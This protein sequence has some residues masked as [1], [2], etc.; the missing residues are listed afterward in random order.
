MIINLQRS[1]KMKKIFM[2]FLVFFNLT[3]S[4]LAQTNQSFD[5]LVNKVLNGK[6]ETDTIIFSAIISSI[7]KNP[8]QDLVKRLRKGSMIHGNYNTSVS[9]TPVG[10]SENFYLPYNDSE[11][12]ILNK[13][14]E[15]NVKRNQISI[16]MRGVFYKG[17]HHID[18]KLFFLIDKIWFL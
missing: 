3:F 2:F 8:Q 9:F 14:R 6:K 10:T 16:K 12:L 1:E 7:G 13:L 4:L 11:P 17:Y 5:S 18:R 15:S